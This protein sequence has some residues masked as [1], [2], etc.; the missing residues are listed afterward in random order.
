M[1]A[2]RMMNYTIKFMFILLSIYCKQAICYVSLDILDRY[3]GDCPISLFHSLFFH[4]H[5]FFFKF[6]P[7]FLKYIIHKTI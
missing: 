4:V 3:S 2:K 5:S 1:T 6:F 7:N